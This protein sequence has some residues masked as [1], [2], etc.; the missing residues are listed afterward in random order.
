MPSRNSRVGDTYNAHLKSANDRVGLFL[1]NQTGATRCA[2]S[3]H[4]GSDDSLWWR[5][6]TVSMLANAQLMSIY[7]SIHTHKSKNPIRHTR[8]RSSKRNQE[9]GRCAN[10]EVLS[11][12][13]AKLNEK[14]VYVRLVCFRYACV[15]HCYECVDHEDYPISCYLQDE[16]GVMRSN[17]LRH[18]NDCAACC[19]GAAVPIATSNQTTAHGVD[20]CSLYEYKD[21]TTA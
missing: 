11:R 8:L 19:V 1:S 12:E 6:Q 7:M 18:A 20:E 4:V 16:V 13:D 5:W 14:N 3:T 21:R 9:V 17:L 15:L 2:C 10:V